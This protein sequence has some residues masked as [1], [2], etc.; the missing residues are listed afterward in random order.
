M[1]SVIQEVVKKGGGGGS[2]SDMMVPCWNK[3]CRI[4]SE[5]LVLF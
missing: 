1:S 2:I 5:L 4:E 3:S